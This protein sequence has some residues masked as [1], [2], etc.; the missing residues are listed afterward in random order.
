[1][2]ITYKGQSLQARLFQR[3]KNDC[4]T[5]KIRNAPLIGQWTQYLYKINQYVRRF[6]PS[7]PPF[8]SLHL[9]L[10]FFWFWC[11]IVY[12]FL[13]FTDIT[14][15]Y[16]YIGWLNG[17]IWIWSSLVIWGKSFLNWAN[18][19][20]GCRPVYCIKYTVRTTEIAPVHQI[21]LW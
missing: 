2:Y 11:I 3:K 8:A 5:R 17:A 10:S 21:E 19:Q 12:L 20:A 15:G 9:F 7:S 1:M 16:I 14:L 6:N 18:C 4:G 13:H